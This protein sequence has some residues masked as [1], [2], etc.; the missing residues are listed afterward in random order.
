MA[1]FRDIYYQVRYD[2]LRNKWIRRSK[3]NNGMN[4]VLMYHHVTDEYVDTPST[5]RCTLEEFRISINDLKKQGFSFVDLDTIY[6]SVCNNN[7]PSNLVNISFDDVPSNFYYNAFP[8]LKENNIPFTLFVTSGFLDRE[9]FLSQSQLLELSRNPLCTVGAHTVTHP[10]LRYTN[11]SFEEICN[12]KNEIE[13]IINKKVNYFAY[14]YGRQST[15]SP[16]NMNEVEKAGFLCAFG[17]IG[18]PLTISSGDYLF[19]LPRLVYKGGSI[20]DY[21]KYQFPLLNRLL[22]H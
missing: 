9:G 4:L 14:P 7:K 18:S 17:T 3:K 1:Y 21:L 13:S 10:R 12:S 2:L 20:S 6:S 11:R 19:Y 22:A 15:V 16:R 5:C 8:L